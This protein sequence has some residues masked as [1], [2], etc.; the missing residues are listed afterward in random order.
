[1][2]HAVK[3]ITTAVE[4]FMASGS[5][6]TQ[7]PATEP[8]SSTAGIKIPRHEFDVTEEEGLYTPY[9]IYKGSKH[10]QAA[11][12]R[13]N[14]ALAPQ[15]DVE[16]GLPPKADTSDTTTTTLLDPEKARKVADFVSA[17]RETLPTE[18]HVTPTSVVESARRNQVGF[19]NSGKWRKPFSKLF[20]E[21]EKSGV[22]GS[23][24]VRVCFRDI[25][26]ADGFRLHS[27]FW[28]FASSMGKVCVNLMYLDVCPFPHSGLDNPHEE[29]RP[30]TDERFLGS[31]LKLRMRRYPRR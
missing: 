26:F 23:L 28:V 4:H 11:A 5:I 6:W 16:R 10:T 3:S 7:H 13:L 15:M 30:E 22:V 14:D 1:M 29:R 12:K 27:L 21:K 2:S 24:R 19:H 9:G 25:D 18:P 17:F 8:P 31:T 20:K